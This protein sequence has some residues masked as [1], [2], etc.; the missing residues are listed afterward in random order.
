MHGKKLE[1]KNS[2][3]K[4]REEYMR[5]YDIHKQARPLITGQD[6]SQMKH[7]GALHLVCCD[8]EIFRDAEGIYWTRGAWKL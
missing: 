1:R 4:G 8:W 3:R 5:L 6:V 2:Q 7:I